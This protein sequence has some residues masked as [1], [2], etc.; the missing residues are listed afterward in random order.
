MIDISHCPSELE[1]FLSVSLKN[2]CARVIERRLCLC[3]Q[4]TFMSATMGDF[5]TV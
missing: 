3:D 2:A 4:E 5:L 1:I